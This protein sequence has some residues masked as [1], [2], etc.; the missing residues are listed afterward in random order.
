MKEPEVR[1]Y[2]WAAAGMRDATAS[3]RHPDDGFVKVADYRRM[4]RMWRTADDDLRMANR[5]VARREQ[6]LETKNPA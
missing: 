1:V 5:M 4:V 2:A 3:L 6:V